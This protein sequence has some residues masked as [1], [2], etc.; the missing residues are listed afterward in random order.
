MNMN[1][2]ICI[3]NLVEIIDRAIESGD[4]K[5]DGASDPAWA[6]NQAKNCLKKNGWIKDDIYG[7]WKAPIK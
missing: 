3:A 4:W 5:V 1:D 7:D 6:I 2:L